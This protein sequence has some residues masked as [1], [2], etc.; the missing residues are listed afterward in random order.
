MSDVKKAEELLLAAEKKKNS[1]SMFGFGANR[2][3]DA[4]EMYEK[5]GNLFKMNSAWKEAGNAFRECAACHTKSASHHEA[6][7]A[8]TSAAGCFKKVDQSEAI[9]CQTEA[10]DEY[11][12]LGRFAMAAKIQ[13]DIA[14]NYESQ[15]DF[16]NAIVAYRQ[17]AN[18][19]SGEDSTSSA[20]A[21]LLKVAQFSAQT[22]SYTEAID[23]YEQVAFASLD[24][25]LLKWSV[26]DYFLRAGL[27]HICAGD[28]VA[29]E[30]ALDKYDNMDATFSST[31]EF[32]LLKNI[33]DS[34]KTGDVAE[35]TNQVADYDAVSKLDSWKKRFCCVLR[36]L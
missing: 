2:F 29:A 21:C 10:I 3:E 22:E 1:F 19:Y 13:K 30:K 35:F 5:A 33:I 34:V 23:L 7:T 15:L 24:S 14:E 6:A 8:L 18:W 16:D 36:M 11:C 25:N 4:A 27:C 28:I 12:K 31:R 9:K 32:S 26:K 20:N 17:A